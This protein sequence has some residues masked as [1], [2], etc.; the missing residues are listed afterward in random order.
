LAAAAAAL[1]H[2]R[3]GG[4]G[5]AIVP[6]LLFALCHLSFEYYFIL[7]IFYLVL[8]LFIYFVVATNKQQTL[9]SF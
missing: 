9:G 2:G 5:L 7:L 3:P 6:A 1:G 4:D 8:L